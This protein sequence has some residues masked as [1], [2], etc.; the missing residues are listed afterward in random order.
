MWDMCWH[1][2]SPLMEAEPGALPCGDVR[3][4]AEGHVAVPEATSIGRWGLELRDT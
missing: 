3:S 1:L 2:S 4:R